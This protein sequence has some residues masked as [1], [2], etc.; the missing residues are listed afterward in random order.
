MLQ[1]I[2]TVK[3]N[4]IVC[5][6]TETLYGFSCNAYSI[7]AIEK[8]FAIKKREKPLIICYDSVERACRDAVFNDA[9]TRLA[10]RFWPGP[11]TLV[12]RRAV[13]SFVPEIATGSD[14]IAVR[15]SPALS[16]IVAQCDFPIVSTSANVSG[17]APFL[18]R[19]DI[20]AAFPGICIYEP[21]VN[22]CEIP[23][24]IVDCTCDTPVII[25]EGAVNIY[26]L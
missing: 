17:K 21:I 5:I 1:V 26:G 2:E 6:K 23:S 11:L 9:A 15:V 4:K 18:H 20:E 14:S 22:S 13:G 25:R 19:K 7:S 16:K 3:N 10:A 12:L 8:I 24:T